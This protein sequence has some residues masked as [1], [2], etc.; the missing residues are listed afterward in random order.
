M[1][2][3]HVVA[4]L[5]AGFDAWI[6]DELP[7]DKWLQA[8]R[9]SRAGIARLACRCAGAPLLHSAAARFGP[10]R[11][12]RTW[13]GGGAGEACRADR[14]RHPEARWQRGRCRGRDRLCAR[15]D[16][17]ARRKY[18]RRRFHGDPLRR[19]WPGHHH[20][21]SRDGAAGDHAGH[22]PRAGRQARSGEVARFRTRHRRARH[23]RRP[24]AGARK[25]RLRQFHAGRDPQARNC[26]R[27]RRLCRH[28]RH[29]RHAVGHVSPHVA[30][31][32]FGEGLLEDGRPSARRGRYVRAE[33]P[34]LGAFRHCR[35]G[36]ARVLRRSG[37]GKARQD[38]P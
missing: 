20:R 36:T 1:T 14:R 6:G 38:D 23:G 27:A 7:Y 10:G 8:F 12:G 17:S 11:S 34:C 33:R 15:R 26:A 25:V 21:L 4:C 31:A 9:D 24:G 2:T 29:G 32:E 3:S 37:G 13:H 16:L 22:L 5:P 19:A 30:V 18:R 28:R 35:A